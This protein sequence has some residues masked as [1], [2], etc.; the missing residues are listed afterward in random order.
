M[1]AIDGEFF[2]K[3]KRVAE[4]MKQRAANIVNDTATA[5]STSDESTKKTPAAGATPS[6]TSTH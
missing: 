6:S 2:D 1:H 4:H 3:H 5:P